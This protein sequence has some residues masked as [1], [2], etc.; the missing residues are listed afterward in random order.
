M[1]QL[2]RDQIPESMRK[3]LND[4]RFV[5]IEGGPLESKISACGNDPIE[6]DKTGN[7]TL[8]RID[9]RGPSGDMSA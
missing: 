6:V 3:Q 1:K 2:F 9:E 7:G 4:A 5:K 8:Y